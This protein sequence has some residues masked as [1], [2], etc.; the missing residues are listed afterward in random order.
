[1]IRVLFSNLLALLCF[2]A[3][4]ASAEIRAL[5]VGVS[6]YLYIDADL[7]GPANDVGL[8][9]DTLIQRGV[10]Q[11]NIAVL[12]AETARVP[13]GVQN[14]GVPTRAAILQGLSDLA[15]VARDGD[16]VFIYYSGHGSQAPDQ[17]GDEA[18]GMDEI[19]L[20]ADTKGWDGNAG[21]VQGA[22]LDDELGMSVQAILSTGAQV[23]AV[24]DAC[25]SGTGFRDL[26]Q[27]ATAS[28]YVSPSQLGLPQT[29]SFDEAGTI[30]SGFDGDF[31][32]FYSAQSDERAFETPVGDQAVDANWYGDFTRAFA[33]VLATR[34]ELSWGQV[35]QVSI[36]TL[37]NTGGAKQTPDAEGTL[38]QTQMFGSTPPERSVTFTNN[39]LDAGAIHGLT[40][41]ATIELRSLTP[42]QDSAQLP[43]MT[44][45]LNHVDALTST[46]LAPQDAP[47]HGIARISDSGP[48]AP[49][50]VDTGSVSDRWRAAVPA[51]MTETTASPDVVL[52]PEENDVIVG[53]PAGAI[54]PASLR[55]SDPNELAPLLQNI[56]ATQRLKGALA[57][58]P[59]A[60]GF[61]F[62]MP[63]TEVQYTLT[64]M[65]AGGDCSGEV[66]ETFIKGP[67][68]ARHCDQ[69][70]LEIHNPSSTAQDVT[71]L[72]VNRDYTISAIWPVDGLSNR[73]AYGETQTVGMQLQNSTD[74]PALEEIL[75][76][77][78]AAQPGAPRN[79]LTILATDGA[80][81]GHA[82]APA[83]AWIDA[84]LDP[85]TQTRAI[86]AAPKITTKLFP[87]RLT[88][89]EH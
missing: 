45:T 61:S 28:R 35:L 23:I 9:A 49:F 10:A 72:Y 74:R 80:T 38:I 60:A 86:D 84:Q 33:N 4:P 12:A 34:N 68:V 5:L 76:V 81:R 29:Q 14:A 25:H 82:N 42:A 52:I 62:A 83:L 48:I 30:A 67:I 59:K 11:E 36:D 57:K 27:S 37:Q 85:D 63:G 66:S 53:Y 47:R 44:V 54:S 55:V 50:V 40:P 32:F 26:P 2:G 43:A 51:M 89:G 17:S 65:D 8:I 75:V 70:W 88:Q 71:V 18:G 73:I 39:R 1:M 21:L 7:R 22:I 41:G 64:Q 79:D 56:S 69:I 46:F 20:A 13:D 15:D 31:V 6:D 24:L 78:V 58:K 87:I 3:L 19:L 16:I 77:A